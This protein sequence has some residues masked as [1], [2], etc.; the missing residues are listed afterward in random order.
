MKKSVVIMIFIFLIVVIFGFGYF[1][2]NFGTPINTSSE[3][4]SDKSLAL[5]IQKALNDYIIDSKDY[6]LSF[7]KVNANVKLE[8]LS[9]D[10]VIEELTKQVKINNKVFGPYLPDKNNGIKLD[11][12]P[13]WNSQQS[14]NN[15][16]WIITIYKR[17]LKV[18][19]KPSE[20][21]DQVIFTE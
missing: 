6:M 2:K 5:C 4:H 12:R 3:Y 14:G 8:G 9:V 19:V 16:G 15:D 1:I 11:Y 7:G 10:E 20:K 17:E 18:T 13:L 21:G